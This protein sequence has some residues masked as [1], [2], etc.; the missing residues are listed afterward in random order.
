MT[1][2]GFEIRISAMPELMH[3]GRLAFETQK[4]IAMVLARGLGLGWI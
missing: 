3:L 4:G 2:S 1:D